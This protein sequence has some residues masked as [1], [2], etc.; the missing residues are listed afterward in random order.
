MI[1]GLTPREVMRIHEERVQRM[2]A[3]SEPFRFHRPFV[4]LAR[5]VAASAGGAIGRARRTQVATEGRIPSGQT[6]TAADEVVGL[7]K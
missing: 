7:A 2:L 1:P 4:R 3:D 6:N 5:A